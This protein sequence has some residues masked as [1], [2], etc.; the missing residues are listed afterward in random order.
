MNYGIY[1][2]VLHLTTRGNQENSLNLGNSR[3]IH[4]LILPKR[5]DF[6]QTFL[7]VLTTIPL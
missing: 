4:I 5:D 1:Y 6:L 3:K 7:N 2:V